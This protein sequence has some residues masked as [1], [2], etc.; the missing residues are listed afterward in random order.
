MS[1]P[2]ELAYY[3]DIFLSGFWLGCKFYVF[4]FF[5]RVVRMV[6]RTGTDVMD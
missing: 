4:G 5:L 6:R 3:R 1:T 2:E